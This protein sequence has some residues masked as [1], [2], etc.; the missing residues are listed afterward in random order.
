MMWLH[1]VGGYYKRASF[2]E[3][4][5][6]KGITRR[7]A[8]SQA[9]GI[10]YG[11]KIVLATWGQN[12]AK[13]FGAFSVDKITL[14][15]DVA[16]AVT[17]DLVNEGRAQLI[18]PGGGMMVRECG[19]YRIGPTWAVD[20]EMDEIVDRAQT[21]AEGKGVKAAFMVGGPL[22]EVYD[23]LIKYEDVNFFRGFKKLKI[24]HKAAPA[25]WQSHVTGVIDYRQRKRKQRK[26]IQ[27]PL[28]L[29]GQRV[30]A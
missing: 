6:R 18:D 29:G 16:E 2:I 9:K 14:N 22:V 7:I 24:P 27:L 30:P 15:H 17:Q 21:V 26:D 20:A 11:D 13:A 19:S 1:F 10:S 5:K 23:P 4:A 25:Q 8:P 28:E 12:G 3:E